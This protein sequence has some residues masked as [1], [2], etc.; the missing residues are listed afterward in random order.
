MKSVKV[1]HAP[2]RFLFVKKQTVCPLKSTGSVEVFHTR[3]TDSWS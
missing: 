3:N 2:S 1:M